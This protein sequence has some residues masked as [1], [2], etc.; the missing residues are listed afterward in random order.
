MTQRSGDAAPGS[1]PA[2]ADNFRPLPAQL[3][4]FVGREQELA[5]LESL[6]HATRLLTLTGAGGS[7]KT[8]L[9]HALAERIV[10]AQTTS[11]VWVELAALTQPELLASE[12]A[13]AMGLR[14]HGHAC[15]DELV[16]QTVADRSLL[17]V[18]DNCEHIVDA[19]AALVD[20]L[21]R[22]CPNVRVL[23]TSRE[24]SAAGWCRRWHCQTRKLAR[25]ASRSLRRSSCS[26]K[27][28]YL[29]RR[30]SV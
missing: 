15:G 10:R 4:S 29:W 16:Q 8:R 25:R 21:L 30:L 26:S 24:V 5:E 7:G 18:L 14:D 28:Q 3:T 12:V 9:A 13:G 17:F 27:E 22:A 19:V 11:V 2:P 6:L 1:A 23:A 20:A